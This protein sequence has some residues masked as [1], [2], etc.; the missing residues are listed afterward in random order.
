[1]EK[2][3]TLVEYSEQHISFEEINLK[4][5]LIVG[6]YEYSLVIDAWTYVKMCIVHKLHIVLND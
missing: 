4:N 1:M 2:T 5:I 3:A 6:I